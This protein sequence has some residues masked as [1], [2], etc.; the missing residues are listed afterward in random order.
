MSKEEKRVPGLLQNPISMFGIFLAIVTFVAGAAMMVLETFHEASHPYFGLITF[1]VM[2]A[3]FGGSVGLTLLGMLWSRRRAK[4][5]GQPSR[6]PVIDL[7]DRKVWVRLMAL[8]VLLLVAGVISA[9]GGYKAY[10]YTESVEFCGLVCHAVM[11]PEHTAFQESPHANMACVDCHIGPGAKWFVKAKISGLYQVYAVLTDKFHRPIET[12]VQN[13]RP[14]KETCTTCHWPQFFGAVLRTWTSYLPDEKNS[15]WTI[16]MLLNIG[17]GSPTHGQVRGIHWHMEGVNTVEYI[18]RDRKRLDIPWVKVTD[19]QG[20]TTVYQA[21]G[22]KERLS[23]QELAQLPRRTMDCIDCHNRPS[24][25]YRSPNTMM[26]MALQSG[27]VDASL[28][29]IKYTGAELLAGKYE[30]E[31]Q[32]LAAIAEGLNEKYAGATNLART[33]REIQ[34]LYTKNMFPE[35]KVRWDE[36]PEHIGH[37]ISPGC[38]RCHDG[39]HVSESG[40]AIRN[41]CGICHTILAQGPGTE[42][43]ALTTAGLEFEHP[44]DIGDEWKNERCDTCHT[45]AP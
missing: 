14:A 38:F 22:D 45:G 6:L 42:L 27:A 7:G 5:L 25:Q 23:E 41:D 37:K 32:A 13:L 33:V 20:K 2:P 19:Q 17:G 8:L 30:T 24:H 21:T 16:K 29:S 34:R 36:Y 1:L 9:V 44:E 10:H 28:P 4:R 18:A 40:Q 12:P 26:D 43:K 31:S 35:M 3:L 15:P 39:K 11:K